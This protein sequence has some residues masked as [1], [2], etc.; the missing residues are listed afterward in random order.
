MLQVGSKLIGY[1]VLSFHVGGEIARTKAA[2]L[3]PQDLKVAAYKVTGAL[4][5]RENGNI[6]MTSSIRELSSKYMVIDSIDELVRQEDV[7]MIDKILKLNFRL[8]GLKVVTKLGKKL[9][10]VIDYT[11]DTK[12]F[13][14]YQLI[15]Q[16]PLTKSLIDPELT[17]N[18]SQI[19]EVSDDKVV[20]KDEKEPIKTKHKTQD[21]VPNFVNPF[22]E[23]NFAPSHRQTPD[24]PDKQ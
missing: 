21:F 15:V 7:V 8:I 4:L 12:S 11:V 24:E 19:V 13:M 10:K 2:I 9:G 23:P 16:R 22:R 20:V 1:A 18:R 17:V 3:D 6:L 5:S 14:I